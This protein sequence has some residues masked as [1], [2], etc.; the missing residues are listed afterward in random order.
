[1]ATISSLLRAPRWSPYV[2]G[3]GIG[4]LSCVTFA[5]MGKPLGTSTTLVRAAG[6]IE[7][8]VAEKSV[9]EN[10]YFSKYLG[11]SEKP[12]P[13]VEWQFA[14][15]VMLFF[16]AWLASVLSGTFSEE[17]V[18]RLWEWRFGGSRALRYVGAFL[19]GIVLLFGA[20]LAGGC[21][22]GHGISGSLQL[23]VSS[24]VFFFSLFAAG[25]GTAFLLYG[26][27]GQKHV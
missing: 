5:L 10:A 13:V 18:P 6:A 8:V 27:E 16:G 20:R 15:V 25:V 9:E 21:T 14:L 7:R 17:H 1:M 12:K 4:I 3:I 22:S 23:A 26:K 11:T 24:W 19:A 2:V